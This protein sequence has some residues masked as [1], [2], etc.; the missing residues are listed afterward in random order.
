MSS[1][2]HFVFDGKGV[3]YFRAQTS[4]LRTFEEVVTW[5]ERQGVR[6][7]Q[8]INLARKTRPDGYNEWMASGRC[9]TTADKPVHVMSMRSKSG[10]PI[11][12]FR[13]L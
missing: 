6:R 1:P 9:G 10:R 13:G 5:F 7:G 2:Q 8:A 12:T 11:V 4:G 3:E